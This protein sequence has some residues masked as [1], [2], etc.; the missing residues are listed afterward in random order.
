MRWLLAL[1]ALAVP[2]GA[3]AGAGA[4]WATRAPERPERGR[5]SLT[6][7]VQPA[8]QVQQVKTV[9][10]WPALRFT[11]VNSRESGVVALYD[12]EGRFSEPAARQLDALLCDA[13]DPKH[14]ESTLL[15]QRTLQ[16]VYR[17]AYHFGAPEVEVISAYRKPGR[18]REGLHASGR[19]IDFK[20]PGVTAAAL[21]QYLRTLPRVGVGVYTHPRTQYVHL[22]VR[23]TSY[24][25][26]DGSPP[27]RTWR[28]LSIGNARLIAQTDASYRPESDLPEG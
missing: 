17:A 3:G 13:R 2:L 26:L 24:H 25:W 7:L 10:K 5:I 20:L 18:R 8:E 11:N 1:A 14:H 19:A 15:N 22:D 28:E 21:A 23:D 9:P 27:G 16:L 4:A 6:P 12:A